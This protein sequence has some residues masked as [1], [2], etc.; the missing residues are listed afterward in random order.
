[1]IKIPRTLK[2]ELL[3]GKEESKK[4]TYLHIYLFTIDTYP[5]TPFAYLPT[6]QLSRARKEIP[7]P[8]YKAN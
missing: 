4:G 5:P 2:M 8:T 3:M 6:D 7:I 1:M